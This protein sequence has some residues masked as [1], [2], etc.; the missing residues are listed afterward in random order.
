[1]VTVVTVVTRNHIHKH[2]LGDTGRVWGQQMDCCRVPPVSWSQPADEILSVFSDSGRC[3]DLS[4]LWIISE[5][6][7]FVTPQPLMADHTG[8]TSASPPS[9]ICIFHRT[10]FVT[11]NPKID[12]QFNLAFGEWIIFPFWW[13]IS[14][15]FRHNLTESE[16]YTHTKSL[17][18]SCLFIV[19]FTFE[20]E[21]ERWE[22]TFNY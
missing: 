1:M 20:K 5:W 16:F 3:W 9:Q 17:W 4:S 19:M 7:Y 18:L 2:S 11:F 10:N 13:A 22:E 8:Y 21:K 14:F 15:T 12:N 6:N